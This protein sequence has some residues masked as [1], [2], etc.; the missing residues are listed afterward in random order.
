MLSNKGYEIALK[1]QMNKFIAQKN[2]FSL[3]QFGKI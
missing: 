3:W 1:V 2:L